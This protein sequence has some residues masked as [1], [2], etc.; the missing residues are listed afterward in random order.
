MSRALYKVLEN[1][2]DEICTDVSIN[3]IT[4]LFC[5]QYPRAMLKENV[6]RASELRI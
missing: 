5:G 6:L 4:S 2:S 1:N 3:K